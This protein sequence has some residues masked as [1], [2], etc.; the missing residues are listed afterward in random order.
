MCA[1]IEIERLSISSFPVG[2]SL[3]RVSDRTNTLRRGQYLRALTAYVEPTALLV[4][5]YYFLNQLYY[6]ASG[7]VFDNKLVQKS[8][9]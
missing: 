3:L 6:K 4:G 1:P 8:S 5:Y 7:T 9:K 2:V